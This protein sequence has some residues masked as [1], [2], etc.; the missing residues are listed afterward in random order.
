MAKLNKKLYLKDSLGNITSCSLYT[1]QAECNNSG[2][3]LKV[4]G[5]D[6][7]VVLGP[8][9]HIR[10]TRGRVKKSNGKTYAILTQGIPYTEVSFTTPG[11]HT[12]TVPASVNRIRVAVCG[13]GG[14]SVATAEDDND[15]HSFTAP[16]GQAS[17]FADMLSAGGGAGGFAH[18][19]QK[20]ESYWIDNGTD[21][22]GNQYGEWSSR[23]YWASDGHGGAG[24]VPNGRTGSHGWYNRDDHAGTQQYQVYTSI[25]GK[26]WAL[27]FK[28]EAGDYG[29]GGYCYTTAGHD[30][31]S[32]AA[33][34]GG[35]YAVAYLGVMPGQTYSVTVG[36]F[37]ANITNAYWEGNAR[38][39]YDGKPG[40]VLIAFGGD[41]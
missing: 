19:V 34:G 18:I 1:T 33:G 28:G 6:A 15:W 32:N 30:W 27:N 17:S 4:D 16:A 24:G 11:V 23:Y 41:I 20:S 25:G 10:A 13:G 35:G 38:V 12:F 39:Y 26:G 2:N 37:G 8:L 7:L 9:D 21:E 5:F 29:T 36:N 14:G 31:L 22:Y 3:P 40:F